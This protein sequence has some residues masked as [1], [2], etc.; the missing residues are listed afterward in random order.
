ML[1]IVLLLLG[2]VSSMLLYVRVR[3][4][5][6]IALSGDEDNRAMESNVIIEEDEEDE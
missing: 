4:A 3:T 2:V 6:R 1:N 5:P